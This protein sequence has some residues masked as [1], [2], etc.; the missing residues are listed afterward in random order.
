MEQGNHILAWEKCLGIIKN[1]VEPAQF[2]T[3]FEP[4]VAVRLLGHTLTLEVPSEFY[5]DQLETQFFKVLQKT[6]V[7]VIGNDARLMYRIKVT[8]TRTMDIPSTPCAQP[9]NKMVSIPT[10]SAGGAS[11]NPYVFPGVQRVNINPNLNREYCFQNLIEGECNHMAVTAGKS[12]AVHPGKATFNPLF[13][14]GG[15]G[16]GKT[17]IAQAIGIAI[18]EQHPEL[19]VQYVSGGRFKVQFMNASQGN[20][21]TDF[22][23]FYSRIDVLILD[24][25][26]ELASPG[27]QKAFFH[28]FNQLHMAGKQLIFTSDRPPVELRN[29][30]ERLSSRLKWGL[31]V[32]LSV[33]DYST[34]VAMLRARSTR[35]GVKL[36]DEVISYLA[37]TIR[38]NFRELEGVLIS[39]IAYST[40]EKKD[41]TLELARQIVSKIVGEPKNDITMDKVLKCVCDYFDLTRDMLMTKSRKRQIVQARQIAMY[42]ARNYISNISLSTIGSEIGGKDHAT[43]LHACT[44][45]QDLMH[46]DKV[47]RQ[48]ITDI[49]KIINPTRH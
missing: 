20:T 32:E 36:S 2:T 11:A 48:Y 26:Q 33:P 43:V 19:I 47:F 23:G 14:Y 38:T 5:R 21:L 3:W 45:V 35:D 30:E 37:S 18:K 1:I 4:L 49:E 7:R 12:I 22:L 29:F 9:E 16:L 39:L 42:F 25:I 34:R 6:L 28:I 10:H 41:I 15:P 46:S 31:S 27:A 24:D 13:I 44:T 8:N 17:H 40:L